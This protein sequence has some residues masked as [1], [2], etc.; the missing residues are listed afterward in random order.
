[1]NEWRWMFALVALVGGGIAAARAWRDPDRRRGI[2][3]AVLRGAAALVVGLMVLQP[4]CSR[5]EVIRAKPLVGVLLDNSQ[6]MQDGGR[7]QAVRDWLGSGTAAELLERAEVRHVAFDDGTREV[8]AADIRFDGASTH[9][10][11]A[12]E[13]WVSRHADEGL[14]GVVLLSD[15][16]DT[17]GRREVAGPGVPVW[18][19]AVEDDAPAAGRIALRELEPPRNA[20]AGSE[21]TVRV[22]IQG[23]GVDG[24]DVPVE[25]WVDG[26]KESS[27]VARFREAGEVVELR[28]PLRPARPGSHACELRVGHPAAD[29]AAKAQPFVLTVRRE[30]RNVMLLENA[31]GFEGKFLRRAL[32]TDRNTRL[33]AYTRWK[34][35]RWALFGDGGDAGA[36][37]ASK[38]DLTDSGLASRDC[39]VVADVAADALLPAQW[40]ALARWVDS[41]GGLV[42][43]GGPNMLGSAAAAPLL[44]RLSPLRLPAAHRD[45]R[46]GVRLTDGGLRHPVFGPLFESVKEF[47]VLQGMNVATGVTPQAQVLLEA[48]AEGQVCPLVVVKAQGAGRV[49]VVASDTLWRWR[50]AAAG[51]SGRTSPYEVFWSQMIDW[52]APAGEG[53]TGEG[54]LQ[55]SSDRA[56]HRQGEEAEIRVEWVGRGESPLTSVIVEMDVPPAG[57]EVIRMRPGVWQ[58]EA[59]REV[60]GWRGTVVPSA[61]GVH[62]LKAHAV[63]ASG[64]AGASMK[65]AVAPAVAERRGERADHAFLR[66]VAKASG[67]KFFER[68]KHGPLPDLIPA[69]GVETTRVTVTDAWN[70]PGFAVLLFGLLGIEWWWRRRTGLP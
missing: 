39:V 70:H 30:G 42:L 51:W 48:V 10:A 8:M 16:L 1:M 50:V 18:V 68:G 63:W 26:A 9:L 27:R 44:G 29:P 46:F 7:A 11:E 4:Q 69:A 41:G 13:G 28:L 35:G 62:E 3:L 21:T 34:D 66:Q 43:L 20:L 61:N 25:V 54:P 22:V 38:L 17:T 52:L 5:R 14:A 53:V 47:P 60:R 31:L 32:V 64:E 23:W 37:G 58:D 19:V 67:G 6:S 24:A 40:L 49:A 57:K 12:L 59:G 15:G 36:G 65:L 2:G 55:L 33:D 45:G 56:V